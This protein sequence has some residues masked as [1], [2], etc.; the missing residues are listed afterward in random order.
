MSK[1]YRRGLDG[2]TQDSDGEIRQKRN[3]TLVGTLRRTYGPDFAEGY[4]A[5]AKLETVLR[6]ERVSTLSQLLKKD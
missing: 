1:Q 6:E 3:D 5:D 2:R 4:R